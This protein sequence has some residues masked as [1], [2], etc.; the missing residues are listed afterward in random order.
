MMT[1][2]QSQ[3]Q[4]DDAAELDIAAEQ[5]EQELREE[6]LD[7]GYYDL[8]Y[9]D[10]RTGQNKRDIYD[11]D[12]VVTAMSELDPDEFN[13]AVMMVGKD[14]LQCAKALNELMHRAVN[15]IVS[16]AET[17]AGAEFEMEQEWAA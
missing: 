16:E 3:K 5:V 9:R 12:S 14:P 13:A 2:A 6:L 10:H 17:R 8:W 15:K 7:G 1:A 4:I 11:R